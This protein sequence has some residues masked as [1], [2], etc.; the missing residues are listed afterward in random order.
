M[1]TPLR[2]LIDLRTQALAPPRLTAGLLGIFA[3]LALVV[4]AVGLA[5]VIGFSVSQRTREFG[6]RLALGARRGDVVALVLRQGLTLV[7]IGLVVGV[8]GAIA[9]ARRLSAL[10]FGVQPADPAT[11]A[12]AVVLLVVVG[13]AACL[14]PARRASR[15]DPLMALKAD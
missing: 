12:M 2:I 14:L 8:G 11:L 7:V 1:T 13:L 5:G 3:G 9:L 4:T 15:V 6:V 10:L